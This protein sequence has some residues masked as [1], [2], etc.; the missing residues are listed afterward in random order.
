MVRR[1]SKVPCTVTIRTSVNKNTLRH[2]TWAWHAVIMG[3]GVVSALLHNFPY[4]NDSL[5]LKIAALAI[6]LLNLVLFVFVCTCTIL[7]YIMFPEI[8]SLMIHHPAQSLFIG[9]F[10]MGAATLINSALNIN[11]DWGFGG[12]AFLWT[13]W[14]FWWL[15]SAVSYL[16]A[17][18]MLYIMMT[19]QDHSIPKMTATWLLP[20]VTLIV[21]SSSG[22]LMAHALMPH[23]TTLALVTSAFSFTMVIIGLS[24]ALMMITVYLLRLI[25]SGTPDPSLILSA[26]ITLGPLGQ[27]GFS[28]LVNGQ[29]LSEILPLH[30]GYEFPTIALAGQMVFAGC[31]LGAYVLF[32]M[33]VAWILVAVI[34]ILHVRAQAE[35]PFS[36]AYWGLIFPNGVFALLCVEL[37]KVLD[38]PVF[39]AIGAAW[40][41]VVFLLWITVFLRSIPAFI[42]GSMFKAPYVPDQGATGTKVTFD[43]EKGLGSNPNSSSTVLL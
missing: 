32:S 3:T 20:V 10:P 36:M 27:G 9:C 43:P 42:D 14:G 13:L 41:G 31:F 2:F 17:F 40:C 19:R 37:A 25:T 22:G 30:M 26:F 4:H 1:S 21:A 29:D 11:Q 24:F 6:F 33:G 34:T 5:A 39:R 7:R 18:G 12:N 28:L 8:W 16:I 15:D 38:S 23:S 35:M